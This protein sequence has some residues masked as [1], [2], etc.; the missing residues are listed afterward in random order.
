[1]TTKAVVRPSDYID[2][3]VITRPLDSLLAALEN[4]IEREWPVHLAGIRGA[5]A[6]FL[7]TLRTS[8]ATYRS[9]RYLC[10]DKPP[11]PDRRL[12][13]SVS[14]PPLNRTILDSIFTVV[15]VLEDPPSRCDWF[16]AA[17]WR[18]TRIEL[19]RH[20]AEY[21][22]LPE[23]RECQTKLRAYSD[24]GIAIA[25]V[26]AAQVAQPSSIP[27][28]PNPG[29]M[30]KHG[31]SS[32]LPLPSTRAF[33][34]Y[35]NDWFYADLS[36]Q[37][38]LGGSGLMKRAGGLIN[39]YRKNP[40][41]E[42]NLRRYKNSQVGQT[43]SLILVL[44]SEMEAYFN[45]GLR[46]RLQY[47]WGVLTPYVGVAKELYERRYASLLGMTPHLSSLSQ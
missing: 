9:V 22:H 25:G 13:Y 8:T 34:K 24:A 7:L 43:V 5:H 3:S 38:H 32:R 20:E 42:A 31:A 40:D 17:D 16:F 26:S 37:S 2:F 35:L 15:F 46:E 28:W 12:E 21:G 39:D 47:V 45:F 18:E 11:D 44:A 10:A 33:L 1:M 36:Q 41:T 29:G 23:W 6:L 27:K 19:E 30:V 14:V 4:K